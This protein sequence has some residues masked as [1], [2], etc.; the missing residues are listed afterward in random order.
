[1]NENLAD[2][3]ASVKAYEELMAAKTKEVNALSKSI[4]EKLSRT[5]E[6]GVQIAEMKEDLGDNA[7][8]L[9]EDKAFLKDLEKNCDSKAAI[10]EEEKKMRAEE[11]LAL[12]ETI[13]ILNDD[14]AL[15]LFKSTLPS[16]G[17]SF[18][19]I[20]VSASALRSQVGAMLFDARASLPS[21]S[22]GRM[23]LD[24]IALA[25]RGKKVGFER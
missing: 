18:A 9:G 17:S 16:P 4:E 7:D 20:Q 12:S 2:E 15:D 19:Q 14:D 8:S 23:Q 3:A 22:Q 13:K 24:F 5:A 11:I 10:H 1:M 6:V 21:G 25:L